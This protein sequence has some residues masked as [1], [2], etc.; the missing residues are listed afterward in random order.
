MVVVAIEL[1]TYLAS[2]KSTKW[3]PTVNILFM[4]V[5]P[6]CNTFSDE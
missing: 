6:F 1:R 5:L 4:H 3:R 2:K